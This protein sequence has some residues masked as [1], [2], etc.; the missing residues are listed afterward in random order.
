MNEKLWSPDSCVCKI[1]V[2]ENFNYLDWIEKCFIHK[3]M[4]D[5]AFLNIVLNHNQGFNRSIGSQAVKRQNKSN[6]IKRINALG[7]SVKK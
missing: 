4:S 7:A 6:E 2:D 5:V 3:N 1:I